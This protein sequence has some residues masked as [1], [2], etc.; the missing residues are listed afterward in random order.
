MLLSTFMQN[1]LD[2]FPSALNIAAREW[3]PV[4]SF[5]SGENKHKT[6]KIREKNMLRQEIKEEY[7]LGLCSNFNIMFIS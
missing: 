4:H 1:S 3:D 2:G 7:A 6:D 5:F